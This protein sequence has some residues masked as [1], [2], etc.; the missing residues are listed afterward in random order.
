MKTLI[1]NGTIVSPEAVRE[2]DILLENGRVSAIGTGLAADGAQVVDARDR[3]VIPGGVDA[4]THITLDADA[5]LGTDV[6]FTGTIPAVMGG[7]TTIIDHMA[8]APG[9]PLREQFAL[10]QELAE[11]QAV[12]DYGFHGVVQTVDEQTFADLAFLAEQGCTSVKAYMTYACRLTDDELL[13]LLRATRELGLL[14]AVHAE[15]H[16]QSESLR[17]GF[18]REGKGAPQWHA[19][20]RPAECEAEAVA[21]LLHLASRAGDAPV[22]IV[23]LST[24]A[25]LEAIRAARA[26]GQQNVF[27]ETCPQYLVLTEERYADPV[28]GLRYIMSPPL[29]SAVDVEALWEGIADGYI[30]TVATDHCAFTLNQKMRGLHDFSRCPGGIP[31][32]EERL[33]L[34]FSEGVAKGRISL[35]RFV[36]IVSAAPAQL[37]GLWPRKGALA[38]GSDADVVIFDPRAEYVLRSTHL[39]GPGD[40]SAYD[41]MRLTG[42]VEAVFLRGNKV[43]YQGAFAAQR[44][45]GRYLRRERGLWRAGKRRQQHKESCHVVSA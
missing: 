33:A 15:N 20:S 17:E 6:F 5:A 7:T 42:R 34:L 43:A 38:P 9:R 27:A 11:Q 10:Y 36:E 29:R 37:F 13:R 22:Y 21:R 4:H 35:G 44:G 41:G 23:H 30:Q 32:L 18:L 39:H 16:E 12:A 28:Q 45:C 19:R 8:F 40:Y 2:A 1:A 25:G 3:L 14:L 24:A 31:G 26:S